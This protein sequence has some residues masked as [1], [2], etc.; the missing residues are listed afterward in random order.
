MCRIPLKICRA[1]RSQVQ[2]SG[3]ILENLNLRH[4]HLRTV[5]FEL[6]DVQADGQMHNDFARCCADPVLTIDRDDRVGW[7]KTKGQDT[8]A[9]GLNA[10]LLHGCG[11]WQR[12]P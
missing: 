10:G 9:G 4:K 6:H 7:A 5:S 12:V 2:F 11:W 3:F 1:R 8:V